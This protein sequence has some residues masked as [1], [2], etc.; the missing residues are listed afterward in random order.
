M[1]SYRF[2]NDAD[3]DEDTTKQNLVTP[4]I[5]SPGNASIDSAIKKFGNGS[6][7]L[8]APNAI[9]FPGYAL[10]NKEWSFQAWMSVASAHHA[11]NTKPLLFDVTPIGGDSIQVELD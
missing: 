1:A 6:L 5:Q 8:S 7:K 11:V 2:N 3:L 9:K 10:Q 4:T